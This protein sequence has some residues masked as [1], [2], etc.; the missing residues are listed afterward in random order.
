MCKKAS[1]IRRHEV[2]L[3]PGACCLL[4]GI[5]NASS[6]FFRL[7]P[8]IATKTNSIILQESFEVNGFNEK[9]ST[10]MVVCL[11]IRKMAP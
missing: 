10:W 9:L 6:A 4:P 5:I 7:D 8:Q 2:C 1:V 11:Q 3:M